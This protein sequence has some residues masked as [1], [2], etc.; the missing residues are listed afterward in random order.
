MA[1]PLKKQPTQKAFESLD[2]FW[3]D[4]MQDAWKEIL[5]FIIKLLQDVLQKEKETK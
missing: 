2:Q 4:L 1:Q 3:K 5:L